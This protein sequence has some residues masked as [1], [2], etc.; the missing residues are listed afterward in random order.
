MQNASYI[1]EQES[2]D[3]YIGTEL[4][5]HV[6]QKYMPGQ[7]FTLNGKYYE[8][9]S[10]TADN[11]ILVRR[12]SEHIG[13]RL[14]YRQVRN[15]T[16]SH[17][18]DSNSMGALKSVNNINIHYQYA[19]FSVETPGYWK[20]RARND[21]DNGDLVSVNGVPTREYHHKQILKFD[22][23]NFG[24]EFTDSVRMTLTNLLNEAFVTL[25]AEN[26]AFISAVTPGK[27][28]A[29]L[30][31]SLDFAEE[32]ESAE[33]AGN[34]DKCIFIIE[35]SQLDIGLLIAVERNLNRILQIIADY[36]AWNDETIDE[37]LREPEE[38]NEEKI[39]DSF[40][41]YE[42]KDEE[43]AEAKKGLFGR[44]KEA[45]K[46]MFKKKK[47]EQAP[48]Q[49]AEQAAE[50]ETATE[51]VAEP[52]AEPALDSEEASEPMDEKEVSQDE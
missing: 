36:L 37:S 41:V 32:V 28:E 14:A 8:M 10:T 6:Y 34:A 12:A 30:T 38:S 2:K 18:E 49:A 50:P 43:E 1:A 13:G 26:Q 44:I 40:D 46:N 11:R 16:I 20:L 47:A 51:P 27:Y 25:F 19:D 5:G 39:S 7:F 24:D 31:Y 15:Y 23:S 33:D 29:P 4:K 52:T 42:G 48:E 17:L 3:L 35:D 21:F 9:V 22:F 45:F